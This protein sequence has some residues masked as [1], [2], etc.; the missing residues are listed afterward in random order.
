M[1]KIAETIVGLKT[2]ESKITD[3]K[4]D[5]YKNFMESHRDPSISVWKFICALVLIIINIVG[6]TLKNDYYTEYLVRK[7]VESFFNMQYVEDYKT[8]NL[9]QRR[10]Q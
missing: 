3:D 8:S 6:K 4:M 10:L 1:K 5:K 9:F 7:V 2:Y